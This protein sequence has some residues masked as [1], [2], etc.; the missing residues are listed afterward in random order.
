MI[1]VSGP[2]MSTTVQFRVAADRVDVAGLVDRL[3]D[4]RVRARRR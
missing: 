3:D 1:S 2:D 4:E